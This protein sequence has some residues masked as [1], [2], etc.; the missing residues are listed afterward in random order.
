M[1]GLRNK[2]ASP[3]H[4][5]MAPLEKVSNLQ[6]KWSYATRLTSQYRKVIPAKTKPTATLVAV[7]FFFSNS[8]LINLDRTEEFAPFIF[9]CF[10]FEPQHKLSI[11]L[12]EQNVLKYSIGTF[13]RL[14]IDAKTTEFF[15]V[16]GTGNLYME[17]HVLLSNSKDHCRARRIILGV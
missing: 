10:R 12:V 9:V 4:Q 6:R 1:W 5:E 16:V 14:K 7:G 17:L 13:A 3:T 11:D 8:S 15:R 2:S